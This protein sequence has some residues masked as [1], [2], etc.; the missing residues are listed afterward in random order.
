MKKLIL[1]IIIL[2]IPICVFTQ[3][4]QQNL[5]QDSL[6]KI[7]YKN[8]IASNQA[9]IQLKS[10]KRELS[11][12]QD[13]LIKKD[14]VI[15][16]YER[17]YNKCNKEDSL[18]SILLLNKDKEIFTLDNLYKE[19]RRERKKEKTGKIISAVLIPIV[20]IAGGFL[21]YYLHK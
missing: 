10:F 5:F 19:E 14:A 21:G 9:F 7:P 20:G 18:N 6:V 2:W 11:I 15:Q 4:F 13:R 16:Y 3:N 17:L 1:F 8:L 12:N